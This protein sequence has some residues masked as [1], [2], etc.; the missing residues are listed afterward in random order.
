VQYYGNRGK[1]GSLEVKK[2]FMVYFRLFDLQKA[3]YYNP[4]KKGERQHRS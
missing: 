2:D 4:A 3:E 1:G